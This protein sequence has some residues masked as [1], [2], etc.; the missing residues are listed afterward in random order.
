MLT[1]QVPLGFDPDNLLMTEISSSP[2][3]MRQPST[4][5]TYY[6]QV[7]DR[8]IATPGVESVA[9][10]SPL[11][12]GDE[13]FGGMATSPTSPNKATVWIR[14]VTSGFSRTM[15]LT[16][17]QGRDFTPGD[18]SG[19]SDSALVNETL[20][21]S[22]WR[23]DN[24]VGKQI[25]LDSE[26]AYA[27]VGVFKDFRD[28]NRQTPI[29]PEIYLP[30]GKDITPYAA[31]IIRVTHQ[32]T[33]LP[34]IIRDQ[35]KSAD[36]NQPV[37]KVRM[38]RSF[39]SDD[40]ASA[41]FFSVGLG[42]L[43]SATL[44]LA[45]IGMYASLSLSISQRTREIAIRIALGAERISVIALVLS[46]VLPIVIVAEL[47]GISGSIVFGR[48]LSAFLFG[49]QVADSVTLLVVGL[50]AAVAALAASYIPIRSA[51]VVDPAIVLR[52]E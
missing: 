51:T 10:V 12:F 28:F 2:A 35:I 43:G 29:A 40:L 9:V 21:R 13:L 34:A 46:D 41:R 23:D 4:W 6:Q 14:Y 42:V 8:L 47:I 48:F 1:T 19:K 25:T 44:L 39:I 15:G 38:M 17:V 31:A 49:V 7:S 11:L 27:I 52:G 33:Y 37:P 32:E 20:A 22:F 50:A 26:T 36:K 3:F 18:Y 5:R 30:F 16:L 45:F 24:A